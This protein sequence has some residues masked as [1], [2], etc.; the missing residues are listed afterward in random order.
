MLPYSTSPFSKA[1]SS[2]IPENTIDSLDFVKKRL[3]VGLL[4]KF[5]IIYSREFKQFIAKN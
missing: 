4:K 2:V 3:V 1:N 5:G